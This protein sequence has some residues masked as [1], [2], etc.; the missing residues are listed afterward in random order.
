MGSSVPALT[1]QERRAKRQAEASR[2]LARSLDAH[3]VSQ[4]DL[5][6]KCGVPC[7]HASEWANPEVNRNISL[8]DAAAAPH[9]VRIDL[10]EHLLGPGMVAAVLPAASRIDDDFKHAASIARG[11]GA[12]LESYLEAIADGT[13]TPAEAA[14]VRARILEQLRALV[15]LDASLALI[16]K[17][18][19]APVRRLH[20]AG[21][22]VG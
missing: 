18:R 8:A 6:A 13:I 16:E 2:T 12:V 20:I 21:E 1:P 14:G 10:A 19:G 3:N 15:S 17:Q 7:P 9:L 22:S 11:G 4:A 5:A